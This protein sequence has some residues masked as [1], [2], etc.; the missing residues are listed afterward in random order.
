MAKE[1][2]SLEKLSIKL[3]K[4]VGESNV[5][6]AS[7]APNKLIVRPKT[8]DHVSR[9]VRLASKQET[10]IVP[11]REMRRAVLD[12]QTKG[13]IVL[14][15]SGMK[16]IFKIDEENLAV[17]VGPGVLWKDLYE[18]LHG[19]G[20][21]MGAYP[22]SSQSTVGEWMDLGGAGI[23]SYT[24]GFAQDL[25]RTMEIVLADGK[26]INT[27][28]E[29][30]LSNSSG[31]NLNGLFVGADS[32]LGVITKITLKMFPAPEEIR[33]LSYTFPEWRAL[34]DALFELTSLKTTPLNVSFFDN[35][36][37]QSQ[38]SFG[39]DVPALGGMVMNITLAGLKSVVDHDEKVIDGV[40][41]KHNAKKENSKTSQKLWEERFFDA[42]T[43]K[44]EV[45]PA[46]SE[47]LIPASNL[48]EMINDTS[49]LIN[50]T[51]LKGAITGTL[52]DR[53]TV[54]LT[55]YLISDKR[56]KGMRAFEKRVGESALRL[57]GRP[58][59]SSLFSASDLK[60]IYGEGM[61]TIM[62]IK[63]ALDPHNIMNPQRLA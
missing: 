4:I 49:E 11:K 25:V 29:K 57:E 54:A 13:C 62:D 21:L 7:S 15:T 35:S 24:Y 37:L 59:G 52:C 14:N 43:K 6:K 48:L 23:G 40:M 58:T 45:S 30:V 56:T 10:P 34:T 22:A 50:K 31:F 16:E 63:S 5:K 1:N 20:Y 46:F 8:A 2:V 9:I 39:K 17:T 44:G 47:V 51:K 61:N 3:T 27:G 33:P 60:R 32:T 42:P 26:I 18:T 12:A 19:K 28:F 36:H 53:S 38:R 55:P 41:E